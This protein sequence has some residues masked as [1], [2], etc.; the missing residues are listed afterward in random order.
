VVHARP[1]Y[2]PGVRRRVGHTGDLAGLLLRTGVIGLGRPI[3]TTRQLRVL[4]HW[5][6]SLAGLAGAAAARDPDRPALVDEQGVLTFAELDERAAKLAAALPLDGRRPRV[7]VLCRNHRGMVETLLAC[8]KR[9]AEVVLLNTGFG[10]DQLRAVLG[11]LRMDVL[12]ADAEFA[13]RLLAVPPG[14]RRLVVWAD[15]LPGPGHRT[16]RALPGRHGT[17]DQLR[18]GAGR[19]V[20]RPPK[21]YGRTIMLSSGTTGRP[22]GARRPPRPG[23]RPLASMVSRIPLRARQT[24][25]I[26]AP[27]FHAWGYA[28]MQMA[29]ALRCTIV[30]HRRFDPER[31]LQAI[32]AHPD[33][34]LIAVPVMAQRIVDLPPLVRARYDTSRLRLAALSGAALPGDLALRFM[35]AFGDR[36]YNVYGSTETSWVSMA[37]PKDLR[38]SPGSAGRPPRNTVLAILDDAGRP[39]PRGEIGR[40][41]AANEMLFE[42]YTGGEPMEVRDGLLC[43]GDLGHLDRYGM[44]QVDG[45]QDGLVIS[46][47]EKVLPRQ[48]ENAIARLPQV[49]EVAV[50]GV[51]DAEWGQRLAAYV[52]LRPGH[53]LSADAIRTYVHDRVARHA[54]PRDV[55]FVPEL[56]RNAT[57][58]IVHRALAARAPGERI[59]GL[60]RWPDPL[61]EHTA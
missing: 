61:A 12:V 3:R 51:P 18:H 28:A 35:D 9:G 59:G 50:I 47:G 31:T 45:R 27:L 6:T 7:G 15:R 11:E 49:R 4:R 21:V 2:R 25:I 56:P 38:R 30:L 36:L 48:V 40:I 8:S 37:G 33:P 52:V 29:L 41:F 23:L 19:P 10:T 17:V 34:V 58:K 55:E 39:V 20:Q 42:G 1:A 57:G 53:P 43:T 46:G 16:G 44:L 32:A 14:L 5:R 54:V 24:M 60:T 22:R 26:E 13:E